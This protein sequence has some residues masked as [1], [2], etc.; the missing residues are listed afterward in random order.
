MDTCHI[1]SMGRSQLA[2]PIGTM[3]REHG[4][5]VIEGIDDPARFEH[6]IGTGTDVVL[7]HVGANWQHARAVCSELRGR[8]ATLPIVSAAE[9]YEAQV[10]L[11]LLDAGADDHWAP[12]AAVENL[13]ARVVLRSQP[14]VT[15]ARFR[16]GVIE[17]DER[18]Q[19]AFV[20]RRACELTRREFALLSLLARK[21][22]AVISRA[23]VLQRWGFVHHGGSNL[24]DVH[25]ARLRSKLRSG[26]GQ[27]QTVRAR[28]FRLCTG[29]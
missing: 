6:E 20:E 12:P 14:R 16:V 8:S 3:L 25:V 18:Q 9:R 22:S 19:E 28:G 7:L 5:R 11:A 10:E 24:V 4:H 29:E 23:E 15:R 26:A 1:L 27:V 2:L 13:I 17:I 21:P